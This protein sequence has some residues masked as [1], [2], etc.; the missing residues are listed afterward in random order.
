MLRF[1]I[2][3]ASSCAGLAM[4]AGPASAQWFRPGMNDC[5][6]GPPAMAYNIA[7]APT[8]T[9]CTVCAPVV[10]TACVQPVMQTVYRQVP[11]TEFQ[12]VR[13]TVKKPVVEVKYV[14]QAV[15]E[16]KPITETRVVDVPTVSY[17]DITECQTVHRNMGYWRTRHE[18]NCKVSPCQY[19]GRPGMMGWL[20]R[21]SYEMRSAFTPAYRTSRE[22]VPQIVAQVV[23][24]TRRVAIQGSK[25]VAYNVT[26]LEPYQTTRQVAVNETRWVDEEITVMKPTT[27]VKTMA[28]GTQITYQ[29]IG[30]GGTATAIRPLPDHTINARGNSPQRTAD[31]FPPNA[32]PNKVN[33]KTRSAVDQPLQREKLVPTSMPQLSMEDLALQPRANLT[34]EL[35]GA[36][37][38]KP[39]FTAPTAVRV[40]QWIARSSKPEIPSAPAT[41]SVAN[42]ERP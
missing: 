31:P 10:Q 5:D 29:P 21:T 14:D 8:V 9:A 26:K 4:C 30:I 15:T 36:I 18:P 2:A 16:Y 39:S 41:M 37:A 22:Y 3:A 35:N 25:Q 1:L 33:N 20:N 17:Q 38:E 7:A 32:D 23:P 19:D 27:V 13:Q 28:V 40:T 42:T 12:P 34:V 11:V 6:C 24:T